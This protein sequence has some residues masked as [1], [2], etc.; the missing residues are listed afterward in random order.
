MI[1]DF[2]IE[3]GAVIEH[4]SIQGHMSGV[5]LRPIFA[6][7][8]AFAMMFAPFAMRSGSA[9]AAMPANHHSQTMDK[10]HCGDKPAKGTGHKSAGKSCC[11][12]MCTAVAVAPHASLEPMEFPRTAGQ[13]GLYRAGHS[14]LAKLPTPPP[15][16]A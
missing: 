5:S 10:G 12:A 3:D 9:T 16:R 8:I 15:R 2:V 11:L 14:F 1:G 4:P 6:I 13:P 7:L